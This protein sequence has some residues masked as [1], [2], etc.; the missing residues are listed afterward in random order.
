MNI[1]AIKVI[2]DSNLD[3]E[4]KAI[5]TLGAL[6]NADPDAPHFTDK[7]IDYLKLKVEF[8]QTD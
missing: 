7:L 2:Q 4:A 3:K 1:E 6:L 8:I 5:G